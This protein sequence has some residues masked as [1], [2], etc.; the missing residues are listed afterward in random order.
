MFLCVIIVCGLKHLELV[1]C[2]LSN[3]SG[4]SVLINYT[5]HSSVIR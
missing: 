1:L 4:H 3:M 2:G 5:S